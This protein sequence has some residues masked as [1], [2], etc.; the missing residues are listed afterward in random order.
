MAQDDFLGEEVVVTAGLRA[1]RA[2]RMPS[3]SCNGGI[4]LKVHTE[5]VGRD[6]GGQR[7]ESLDRKK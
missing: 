7:G 4:A 2:R 5:S 3:S 1:R 6:W